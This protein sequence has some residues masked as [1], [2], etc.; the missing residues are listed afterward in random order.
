MGIQETYYMTEWFFSAGDAPFFYSEQIAR[1][2]WVP[3]IWN[4]A[5]EFGENVLPRLWLDYP[6]R[7]V[8]KILATVGFDWFIIEKILWILATLIGGFGIYKLRK[9]FTS[10]LIYLTNTYALLL[11][12]GGQLGIALAYAFSPWVLARF[13][14]SRRTL[15][16]IISN[17]FMLAL[18]V[19]FD[20]RIAYIV[21]GVIVFY[22]LFFSDFKKTVTPV[23]I[24]PL[25]IAGAAHAFWILPT[26]LASGSAIGLGESF[27]D[28]AMPKF[29]SFA[30][31]SHALSLLHPNWPEN[32]F[33]KVY[34]LQ[35]EFLLLPIIAFS[36]LLFFKPKSDIRK[37]ISFFALFALIGAFFAKGVN[38]PFG[39]VFQ[40]MFIHVPGFVMFRDPTKFYILIALAYAVLIPY[41]LD[42]ISQKVKKLGWTILPLFIIFWIISIRGV[43]LGQ[44]TGNFTP[45]SVPHE[46]VLLK[47]LLVSDETPSRTLWIPRPEKFVYASDIHPMLSTDRLFTNASV[48]GIIAMAKD[49]AFIQRLSDA[50]VKYV[51]VPIDVER[52]MFLNDYRFDPQQRM[53]LIAALAS[54]PLR[55]D[56]AFSDVAVFENDHFVMRQTVPREV[57]YQQLL[58]NIGVVVS[59]GVVCLLCISYLFF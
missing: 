59:V 44:M 37:P 52:R 27:T 14:T 4:G 56:A 6:F 45:V 47:N 38:G 33:G 5:K 25:A 55:R 54:S 28:V 39:G 11:F 8:V 42:R 19:V 3:T 53:D 16:D 13:L 7:L 34:F 57:G 30:D 2:S 24:A 32:L 15:R 43:F 9:S 48:S 41:S 17:G 58:A 35:P 49:N 22:V 1:I 18:L 40:W 23:L 46:Y 50:G 20:L 51:I 12:A 31:F 21:F 10:V 26:M 36:A 29:L